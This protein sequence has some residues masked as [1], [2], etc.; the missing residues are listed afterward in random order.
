MGEEPKSSLFSDIWA[1]VKKEGHH[2]K[3]APLAFF[4]LLLIGGWGGWLIKDELWNATN[5]ANKAHIQDLESR[6]AGKQTENDHL[7]AKL[8][9]AAIPRGESGI[10]LKKRVQIL[11]DQ[12]EELAKRVAGQNDMVT[13]DEYIARFERRVETAR[14]QLDE[15]GLNSRELD[16]VVLNGSWPNPATAKIQAM[17]TEFRKLAEK[18]PED[19]R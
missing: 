9:D 6:L 8:K 1:H 12:L 14:V 7:E 13:M 16:A 5:E 4:F 19:V 2:L 15:A 10:P 18:T 17:A 3:A 11:A